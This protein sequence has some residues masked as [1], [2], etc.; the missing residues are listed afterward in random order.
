[1][2]TSLSL[3]PGIIEETCRL[4]DTPTQIDVAATD[5]LARQLKALS[6]PTRLQLLELI[7]SHPNQTACICDLTEPLNVTQ[8]TVSHHMR[9]LVEAG[10]VTREQRGKWVHYG[11]C[12]DALRGL[13][14]RVASLA[15]RGEGAPRAD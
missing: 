5:A 10:I 11:I 1:M 7:G 9:L 2:T 14:N 4:S 13:G 15:T 8:P 6:D 12:A 3:D